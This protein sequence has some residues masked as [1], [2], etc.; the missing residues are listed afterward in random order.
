MLRNKKILS[1]IMSVVLVLG[2]I[3]MPS[4]SFAQEDTQ[5]LTVL[6]INDVHGRVSDDEESIIGYSRLK[7]IVDN[8]KEEDPNL[9]LLDA[10]DTFHGTN[11]ANLSRG[12]NVVDLMNL[13]EFD[14]MVPGNHDFNF[15]SERLLQLIEGTEFPVVGANIVDEETGEAVID[16]YTIITMDNE[17]E[18]GIF[19]LSTEETK[20]KSHPNNTIGIDFEDPIVTS[21]RIVGELEAEGVDFIIALSHIGLD[22]ES[23]PT[24]EQ[25]AQAVEGIDLIV[26]GHSHTILEEGLRVGDT[27]IVQASS[28]MSNIGLVEIE[29]GEEIIKNASLISYEDA[30]EYDE[31]EEI[32]DF[33]QAI[34]DENDV[35]LNKVI[36]R[37]EVLLDGARE[38]VR[39]RET[40]LGNLITDALLDLTDADVALTNGGGIRESVAAGDITMNDVLTVLPFENYPAVIEVTGQTIMDALEFGTRSYPEAAGGFPHVAGMTYEINTLAPVG[41]RIENLLVAG[42]AIDLEETYE[43]VTN[44]FMAAGGDGYEMFVGAES[45]QDYSHMLFSDVLIDYI[46]E[47]ELVNPEVEGR[48]SVTEKYVINKEDPIKFLE[49]YED[50]TIKPNGKITRE[51][52]ATVFNRL[53]TIEF[54]EKVRTSEHDFSDVDSEKYSNDSIATLA[55]AN[56]IHGYPDGSFRPGRAITR[57]EVVKIASQFDRLNEVEGNDFK[58]SNGHWANHYINSAA[59]KGWIIG[60]LDDTFRPNEHMTRAEFATLV[61]RMLER[62]IDLEDLPDNPITFPDLNEGSWYYKDMMAAANGI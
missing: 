58:D 32:F 34:N 39:T 10:G 46:Q 17:L 61:N 15:G 62:D 7:S 38:N 14:A 9:L 56:V 54:F 19:G 37:T 1:I 22:E 3:V 28:H 50:G 24:T 41:N 11:F 48:I 21:E 29:M 51:E 36:G 47:Q 25:I 23:A 35:I 42:Q 59:D 60:Y 20:L 30:Q 31:D 43:L 13:V 6:H 8:L 44:D 26:D 18:V 5:T 33:I 12:E 16:E 49:G 55:N 57:A 53:L 27:L 4:M 52:V 2:L 40:N 45:V